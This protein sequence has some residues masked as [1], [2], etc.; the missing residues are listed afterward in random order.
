MKQRIWE[1][2]RLHW[3]Q[4]PWKALKCTQTTRMWSSVKATGGNRHWTH[5]FSVS[6]GYPKEKTQNTWH[7]T[8]LAQ[9]ARRNTDTTTSGCSQLHSGHRPASASLSPGSWS[10]LFSHTVTI[11]SASF[12]KLPL[13]CFRLAFLPEQFGRSLSVIP[14]HCLLI[15]FV[16]ESGA[17][18]G[19]Q[20]RFKDDWCINQKAN[21]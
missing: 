14:S 9:W 2:C 19:G 13:T 17:V 3:E 6:Q 8:W 10:H 11:S 7:Q 16:S 20:V 4:H 21:Y 12:R 18:S 15:N 5:Q 1:G